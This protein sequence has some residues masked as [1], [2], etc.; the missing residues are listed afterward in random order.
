[1]MTAIDL[2]LVSLRGA[3]KE[4]SLGLK[5]GWKD[6]PLIIETRRD[7][8]AK[9]RVSLKSLAKAMVWSPIDPFFKK[10]KVWPAA[11]PE[12]KTS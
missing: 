2:F 9:R 11:L 1:M 4:A 3:W 8:Q 7:V 12:L 10:P 5:H 6:L